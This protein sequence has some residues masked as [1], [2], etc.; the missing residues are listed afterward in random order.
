[1]NGLRYYRDVF[2]CLFVGLLTELRK[3]L[4]ICSHEI[5][6]W[7]RPSRA[8]QIQNEDFFIIFVTFQKKPC[9]V[10]SM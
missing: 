4:C 8:V 6:G 9:P 1:V 10:L 2:V 7:D 3:Q 5:L